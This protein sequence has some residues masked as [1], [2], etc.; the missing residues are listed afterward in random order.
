MEMSAA[1]L[2]QTVEHLKSNGYTVNESEDSRERGGQRVFE[3]TKFCC[4]KGENSFV[5]ELIEYPDGTEA[6][7][8]EIL[9]MGSIR[10]TSFPLDSWKYRPQL[11]EFK[12]CIEPRSGLGLSFVLDL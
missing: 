3:R 5:L 4:Q 7:Y 11:V 9:R 6:Y 8:L 12:Y 1:Y 10:S 2:R